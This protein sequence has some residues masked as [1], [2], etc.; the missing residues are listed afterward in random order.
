[1]NQS[2]SHDH[3]LLNILLPSEQ[4]NGNVDSML[5]LLERVELK[6]CDRLV[7]RQI[8]KLVGTRYELNVAGQINAQLKTTKQNALADDIVKH[9]QPVGLFGLAPQLHELL[10]ADLV[11]YGTVAFCDGHPLGLDPKTKGPRCLHQ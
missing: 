8:H 10:V 11:G 5:G 1:M 3:M 9:D 2:P 7:V 4:A 6:S